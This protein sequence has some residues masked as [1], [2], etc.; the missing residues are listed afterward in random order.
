MGYVETFVLTSFF[1][2]LAHVL[3]TK[4]SLHGRTEAIR[5]TS[6]ESAALSRALCSKVLPS[7]QAGVDLLRTATRFVHVLSHAPLSM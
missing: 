7:K 6:V 1:L 4:H 3:S 2:C 5:G